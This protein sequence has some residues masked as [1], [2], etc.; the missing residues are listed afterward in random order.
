MTVAPAKP[1]C[2]SHHANVAPYRVYIKFGAIALALWGVFSMVLASLYVGHATGNTD[3]WGAYAVGF[4]IAGWLLIF[5]VE[6]AYYLG[7]SKKSA[8]AVAR[9]QRQSKLVELSN[10]IETA[11]KHNEFEL[12]Y[13]PQYSN[14]TKGIIGFEALIRWKHPV[15]GMISPG[16]FIPL[17]EENGMITRIGD[18]SIREACRQIAIWR[19]LFERD[20]TV[21]VNISATQFSD[22]NLID[23]VKSSLEANGLHGSALELEITESLMMSDPIAANRVI[24]GLKEM[25]VKISMDDFGTGYSSLANLKNFDIDA[26]KIDQSFVR[27]MATNEF[28]KDIIKMVIG[29]GDSLGCHVIAEGVETQAQFEM[30]KRMRCHSIQ[31][32]LLSKPIRAAEIQAFLLKEHS[33]NDDLVR[34]EQP[35]LNAA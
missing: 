20:F 15:E 7:R 12:H 22:D 2:C 25:G 24:V 33:C 4:G 17:A 23:V 10:E 35:V 6:N 13:Q 14:L 18:W 5:A 3:E 31:G 28:S 16:K 32:Y 29:I 30:L 21:A 34:I 26:I 11:L 1:N 27:D 8:F 9:Q 19:D